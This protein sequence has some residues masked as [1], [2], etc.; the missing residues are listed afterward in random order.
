MMSCGSCA[1]NN[2]KDDS[3]PESWKGRGVWYITKGGWMTG[4]PTNPPLLQCHELAS[5]QSPTALL[6]LLFRRATSTSTIILML[7]GIALV[8]ILPLG[9]LWTVLPPP[10]LMRVLPT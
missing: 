7:V 3:A 5:A 9:T 4:L 6:L 2:R 10:T 1:V 8:H